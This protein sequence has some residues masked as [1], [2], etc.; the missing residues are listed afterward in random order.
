LSAAGIKVRHLTFEGLLEIHCQLS[1]LP[2][3]R[4]RFKNKANLNY[5]IET[6]VDRN[7]A[8]GLVDK[9][10]DMTA[11]HL[12]CLSVAS[13]FSNLNKTTAYQVADSFLR[14][15]NFH[16]SVAE[17]EIDDVVLLMKDITA[18]KISLQNIK[19]WSRKHI[20]LLPTN[21]HRPIDS[22]ESEIIPVDDVKD[23]T[24]VATKENASL[25]KALSGN[26]S[27]YHTTSF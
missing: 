2:K 1:N 13:G 3:D 25:L 27:E 7:E 24:V 22:E 20:T 26:S 14:A 17:S 6:T 10:I 8:S 18:G 11:H 4:I 15:N 21:L 16:L 23:I 5:C 9:L 12:R 19:D